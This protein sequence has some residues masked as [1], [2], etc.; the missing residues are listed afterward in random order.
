MIMALDGKILQATDESS[1]KATASAA[2]NLDVEIKC[3]INASAIERDSI[4]E[5]EESPY[6]VGKM[7]GI[8]G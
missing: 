5:D 6:Y 8:N 1:S 2:E 4:K 7:I 3:T